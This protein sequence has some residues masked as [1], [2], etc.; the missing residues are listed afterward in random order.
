ME[1]FK[2]KDKFILKGRGLVFLVEN[3]KKRDSKDGFQDLFP[4]V[5]INGIIYQCKGI[6]K[7]AIG[8]SYAKGYPFGILVKEKGEI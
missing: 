2:S 5:E 8:G 1:S 4:E 6:E 3:N 7:Y